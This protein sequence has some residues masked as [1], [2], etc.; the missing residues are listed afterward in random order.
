[1]HIDA[2]VPL[3]V[4]QLL[5]QPFMKGATFSLDIKSVDTGI[6]VYTYNPDLLVTPASVLKIVTTATALELLGDDYRYPTTLA[7]NG[8]IT[9]GVLNGNLYIV[10][11]G[12]PSLGSSHLSESPT[13]FLDRWIDAIRKAGISKVNGAVIADERIF[14]QQGT[15]LKWLKE[16]LGSYYGAGSYGIS[17]FDNLYKLYLKTGA[18]G[19]TPQILRTDP[20]VSYISFHNYLKVASVKSDS[21]YILGFPFAN[22]RTLYGVL[23]PNKDGYTLKGDIPDP[24]FFL[25][26]YFT[27]KLEYNGVQVSEDPSC[28]RIE[29]TAGNRMEGSRR[30]L[31]TTY[32]PPLSELATIC[33]GVSHNLYADAFLKTI[34]LINTSSKIKTQSSF[35]RGILEMNDFWKSKGLDITMLRVYDGSGLAP[36]DKVTAAFISDML[37]YMY[38]E[39]LTGDVFANSLPEAGAGGSVRN[40]L[41]G[42]ALQGNAFL[43][44]GGMTGVRSF[45]GYIRQGDKMY[46]V[47][48][49]ANNYA[50]PMSQMTRSIEKLLL[51]LFQIPLGSNDR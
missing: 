42:S 25:A 13:A 39:S 20:D 15:G 10:G 7:Y 2:Q 4:K 30:D 8:V 44:S 43:K 36:A 23:P 24:A 35:E 5:Q 11:S 26:K 1:M 45:A 32:S 37:V 31:I 40:F 46:A 3:P 34:G 19:T 21:S 50:C 28:Y 41:K 29:Q 27:G 18:T 48:V 16:D 38:N 47:S 51:Q 6:S 12:D 9:N 22:E 49:F 14:D 33:N 17:V